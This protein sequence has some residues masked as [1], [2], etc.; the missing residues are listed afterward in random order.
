MLVLGRKLDESIIIGEN[1]KIKVVSID[2]GVVKLGIE[3]PKDVSI[4]REE[5]LEQIKN[6]NKEAS[7]NSN[8]SELTLLSKLLK[9]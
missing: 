8:Q 5:L 9:K 7:K 6:S 2:R 3:A 1:I 4:L